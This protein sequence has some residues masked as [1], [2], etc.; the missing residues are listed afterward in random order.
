MTALQGYVEVEVVR[1]DGDREAV[2]IPGSDFGLEEGGDW[3]REDDAWSTGYIF[4]AFLDEYQVRLDLNVV[5]DSVT[6]RRMSTEIKD[7]DEVKSVKV[8]EDELDVSYCL[9]SEATEDD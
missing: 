2:T 4:I 5:D 3:R 9:H 8:I 6:L 7:F 1:K